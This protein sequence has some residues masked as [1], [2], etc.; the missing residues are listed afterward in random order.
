MMCLS[1]YTGCIAFVRA[2]VEPNV[3][4]LIGTT[5]P[6]LVSHDVASYPTG[7]VGSAPLTHVMPITMVL[8]HSRR[9]GMLT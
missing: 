3:A 9:Q 6:N 2:I 1:R 8:Y 4:A 7:L 5:F